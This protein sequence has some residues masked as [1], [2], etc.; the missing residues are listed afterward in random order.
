MSG[1]KSRSK[2]QNGQREAMKLW[3]DAGFKDAKHSGML[4]QGL[5]G[6][7]HVPDIFDVGRWWVEIKRYKK[8]TNKQVFDWWTK[9][10]SECP[11]THDPILMYR[12]N[13]D[14]WLVINKEHERPITWESFCEEIKKAKRRKKVSGV[15]RQEK[16]A[17]I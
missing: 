7:E 4:Q 9:L 5:A 14:S 13:Y 2:G 12:R 1:R 3:R 17:T 8:Y 6:S 16:I 15:R 11:K 10:V